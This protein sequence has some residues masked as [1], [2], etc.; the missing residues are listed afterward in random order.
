MSNS[1][2]CQVFAAQQLEKTFLWNWSKTPN[3]L[4]VKLATLQSVTAGGAKNVCGGNTG[5]VGHIVSQRD[6]TRRLCSSEDVSSYHILCNKLLRCSFVMEV[7]TS[8]VNLTTKYFMN[9]LQ[10]RY[11]IQTHFD[12]NWGKIWWRAL[13]HRGKVAVSRG[14]VLRQGF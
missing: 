13:L 7:A 8:T 5:A 11:I 9:R 10:F 6:S 14:D 1:H 2:P 12:G 4:G 3:S